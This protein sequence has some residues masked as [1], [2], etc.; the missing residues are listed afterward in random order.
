MRNIK[1]LSF[2]PVLLAAL[3]CSCVPAVYAAP[4]LV[5]FHTNDVHGHVS[6]ETGEGCALTAI[7][8]D[9]LNAII[10]GESTPYLPLDAGDSLSGVIFANAKKGDLVAQLLPKVGYDALAVGNHEFDSVSA[11]RAGY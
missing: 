11:R 2:V 1:R 8:Y 7:G 3:L 6:P 4:R 5:I 9:R 10:K